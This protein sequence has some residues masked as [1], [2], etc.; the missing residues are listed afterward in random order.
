MTSI[1]KEWLFNI[2]ELILKTN[3]QS[4]NMYKQ[5]SDLLKLLKELRTVTSTKNSCLK[6]CLHKFI[7]KL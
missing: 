2:M 4:K 1:Y 6:N 5:F 3:N 7:N